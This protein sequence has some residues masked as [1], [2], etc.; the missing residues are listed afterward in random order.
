MIR[1]CLQPLGLLLQFAAVSILVF[2]QTGCATVAV[3]EKWTGVD[4]LERTAVMLKEATSSRVALAWQVLADDHRASLR[5]VSF[6]PRLPECASVDVSVSGARALP[7]RV[8]A[9]VGLAL[10]SAKKPR[11]ILGRSSVSPFVPIPECAV[12]LEIVV[13]PDSQEPEI[14]AYTA[15]GFR[16]SIATEAPRRRAWGVLYP[17][18]VVADAAAIAIVVPVAICFA[19]GEACFRGLARLAGA[20]TPP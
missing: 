16:G 9:P 8:G 13:P 5:D 15:N 18:A 6:D 12:W 1:S 20:E 11:R 14:V 10:S 4:R 2:A 3:Y 7:L 17:L 19:A